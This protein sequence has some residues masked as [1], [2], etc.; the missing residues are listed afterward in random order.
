MR[1]SKVLESFNDILVEPPTSQKPHPPFWIG[2]G[3]LSS[4]RRAAAHGYNL[5][6][7]QFAGFDVI[8]E[9]IASFKAEHS[10]DRDR[11]R[12]GTAVRLGTTALTRTRFAKPSACPRHEV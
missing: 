9:R 7:D 10:R 6:L 5:L 2:A 8:R 1:L 11:E 12:F 3:S 4:I